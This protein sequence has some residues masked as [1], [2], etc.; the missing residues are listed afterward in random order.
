ANLGAGKG[1]DQLGGW[2]WANYLAVQDCIGSTRVPLNYLC[3]VGSSPTDFNVTD[4]RVSAF[5][6]GHANGA[7]FVFCD[8]SVRFVTRTSTSHPA[9][10]Q[11]TSTRPGGEVAPTN[12]RPP[13][14]AS[15]TRNDETVDG[16][17]RRGGAA[18][19]RRGLW[20]L[21]TADRRGRGG[22]HARRSALAVRH[23]GV[24]PRVEGLRRRVQLR[25]GGRRERP[26]RAC[27]RVQ[28]TAGGG[29]GDA[30]G[31]GHR[32]DPEGR[33]RYGRRQPGPR[34]QVSGVAGQPPHPAGVRQ[35][36]QDAAARH[37][38]E[39]QEDVRRGAGPTEQVN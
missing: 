15:E 28:E 22:A 10:S 5:G 3:P 36:H 30:S 1:I 20:Q 34:R 4:P 31:G 13:H 32:H 11:A 12:C 29:G 39:G 7:N 25:G 23:G 18:R 6:S 33:A 26:A 17:V 24:H 38:R 9:T 19:R 16:P 2:A 8:G 27:P 35:L 21:P 37:R 14:P